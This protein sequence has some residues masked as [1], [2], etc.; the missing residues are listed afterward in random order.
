VTDERATAAREIAVGMLRHPLAQRYA[1]RFHATG[2]NRIRTADDVLGERLARLAALLVTEIERP[3]FALLPTPK[4]GHSQVE[5]LVY[6]IGVALSATPYLWTEEVRMALRQLEL[7]RHVLSPRLLP[8][9][10]SWHTFHTGVELLGTSAHGGRRY[11]GGTADAM[12]VWDV[13]AEF[14]VATLGEMRSVET[15]EVQP[16]VLVT[17]FP[18]GATYPDDFEGGQLH[19]L[20]ATL[21]MFA[22]LNSPYIPKRQ[23]RASRA[24]RREL[25]RMGAAS[26]DDEHVTF[27]VLRRPVPRRESDEEER[28]VD[29]KHQWLVSGH[30]RAQWYP[31]EQAHRLIWIAPY[32][33]GPPDAPMLD[34]AFKVAR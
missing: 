10:R 13:G 19:V 8:Q 23:E 26:L 34:H 17:S 7:P 22:F 21:L 9:P 16:T 6:T 25:A 15:E 31:S 4:P 3:G 11:E 1:Q 14:Y 18:Y 29:W 12:Y 5:A 24:A 33:K 27:V 32:L 30:L 20:T 28:P 2:D